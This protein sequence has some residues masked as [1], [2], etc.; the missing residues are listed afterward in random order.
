LCIAYRGTFD[1]D[2]WTFRFAN[3]V[4]RHGHGV[5][6]DFVEKLRREPE[7]LGILGDGR[8]RKS[9]LHVGD[10]VDGILHAV[11]NA[12]PDIYNVGSEDTV[13]VTEIAEIGG[14]NSVSIPSSTTPAVRGAGRETF[15]VCVFP[16]R[17]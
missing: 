2:A 4:G 1:F 16:L 6:P 12:D 9:Y 10:C 5:V 14:T 11:E 3:V 15:R 8:Q 13:S 7:R 17:S